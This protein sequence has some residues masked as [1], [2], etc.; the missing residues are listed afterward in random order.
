MKETIDWEIGEGHSHEQAPSGG[1]IA[2]A[3]SF[4]EMKADQDVLIAAL[5]EKNRVAD[6][7]GGETSGDSDVQTT[8]DKEQESMFHERAESTS[9]ANAYITRLAQETSPG[10]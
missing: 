4:E 1:P 9:L 7:V 6:A 5:G 2:R 3:L 8:A 10:G